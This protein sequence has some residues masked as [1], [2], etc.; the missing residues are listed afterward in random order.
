MHSYTADDM[1]TIGMNIKDLIFADHVKNERD[2]INQKNK[3]TLRYFPWLF[4]I[5]IELNKG[6]PKC[7]TI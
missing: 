1:E 7:G 5:V 4:L 2:L 3:R 6:F